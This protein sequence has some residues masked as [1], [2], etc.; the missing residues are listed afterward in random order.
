[1]KARNPAPPVRAL[2]KELPIVIRAEKMA[3]KSVVL[4]EEIFIQTFKLDCPGLRTPT[5]CSII[6]SAR[7]ARSTRITR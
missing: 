2:A 1:M 5:P 4:G 3:R 6:K 7:L